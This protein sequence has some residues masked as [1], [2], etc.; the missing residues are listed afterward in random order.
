M[1]SF[2]EVLCEI[3][4]FPLQKWDKLKISYKVVVSVVVLFIIVMCVHIY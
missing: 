2:L 3:I 1:E 4:S